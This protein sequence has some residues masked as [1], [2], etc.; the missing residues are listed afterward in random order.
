MRSRSSLLSHIIMNNDGFIGKFYSFFS[1]IF[2]D[3]INH[4]RK[5]PNQ[6]LLLDSKIKLIV[7]VRN[8]IDSISSIMKLTK[9]YY[10]PWDHEKS[11]PYYRKRL[12][13]LDR[14]CSQKNKADLLLVDSD[15]L[16]E[17]TDDTLKKISM[18]LGLSSNL[19]SEYS[20]FSFTGVKGDP[21]ENIMSGQ[22]QIDRS[23][24]KDFYDSKNPACIEYLEFLEKHAEIGLT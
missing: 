19:S 14:V 3:Q 11:S 2:V 15:M 1:K 17:R 7:L 12:E 20:K 23:V 6:K 13:Y 21:S 22:V 9:K 10:E 5:T 18:F 24:S 8:P 16:V 4:N